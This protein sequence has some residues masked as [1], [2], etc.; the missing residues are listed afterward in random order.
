[1]VRVYFADYRSHSLVKRFQLCVKFVYIIEIWGDR[2]VYEIIRDNYRFILII[3]GDALPDVAEELLRSLAFKKPR[4]AVAVV[5]IVSG[6]SARGIVHIQD[7]IQTV[8]AAPSDN[9]VQTLET[10]LT[11]GKAHIILVC[12][13]LVVERHTYRIRTC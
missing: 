10:V 6:L 7:H 4:V 13:E 3:L 5:D 12:K 1:M 11:G 9:I 8:L 2:L